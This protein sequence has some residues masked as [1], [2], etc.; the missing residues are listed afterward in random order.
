MSSRDALRR[1]F[2]GRTNLLAATVIDRD[3]GNC[4]LRVETPVG[5]LGATAETPAT[6]SVTVVFRP[7]RVRLRPADSAEASA[8]SFRGRVTGIVYLGSQAR[9]SPKPGW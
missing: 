5:V 3:A 1:R 7:E 2:I 8:N 9:R 6:G 4:L